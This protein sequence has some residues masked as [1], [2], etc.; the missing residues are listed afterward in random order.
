MSCVDY[1]WRRRATGVTTTQGFSAGR[2]P[3]RCTRYNDSSQEII[4]INTLTAAFHRVRWIPLFRSFGSVRNNS[5]NIKEITA[6]ADV[7]ETVSQRFYLPIYKIFTITHALKEEEREKRRRR[8]F[9]QRARCRP[10]STGNT[11]RLPACSSSVCFLPVLPRYIPDA[12]SLI[13]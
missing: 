9:R 10:C 5:E 2:N 6:R 8:S 7:R 12:Y 1:H 11:E 4:S 3:R 13:G